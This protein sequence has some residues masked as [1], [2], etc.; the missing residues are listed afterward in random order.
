MSKSK[1]SK[2]KLKTLSK[3][4]LIKLVIDVAKLNPK[5][6]MFIDRRIGNPIDEEIFIK[7]MKKETFDKV[8]KM[9]PESLNG[10]TINSIISDAKKIGVSIWTMAELE[11]L[12][13][14]GCTDMMNEYG[15]DTDSLINMQLRHLEKYINLILHS[16]K[17][18]EEKEKCKM[19]LKKYIEEK[20]NMITDYMDE[21]FESLTDIQI[22]RK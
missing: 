14:K 17:D 1:Q 3:D 10:R 13:F 7:K 9:R 18:Q 4:E 16:I 11:S 2:Q 22:E 6:E 8:F 5:N 12:A 20:D 15:F 21:V 19:E